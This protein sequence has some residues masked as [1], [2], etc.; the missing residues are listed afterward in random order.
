MPG[1]GGGSCKSAIDRVGGEG[2]IIK[3]QILT[4]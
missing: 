4:W 3:S 1:G 2:G